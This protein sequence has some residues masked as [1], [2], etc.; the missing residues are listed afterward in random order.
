M[1]PTF[2]LIDAEQFFQRLEELITRK[3]SEAQQAAEQKAALPE[4]L[5]RAQ[6]AEFLNVS[7]GTIDNLARAGLLQKHYL[8]SVPRFKREELL[9]AFEGWK[10][11]QRL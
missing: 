8:G 7:R 2:A 3:F 4:L 1:N 10:K 6:A 9:A 5:S 11:F